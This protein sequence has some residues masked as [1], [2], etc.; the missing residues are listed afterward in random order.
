MKTNFTQS[1]SA[2]GNGTALLMSDS[3][4]GNKAD[5]K[6]TGRGEEKRKEEII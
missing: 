5:E 2:R 6:R 1:P 3:Q 4:E